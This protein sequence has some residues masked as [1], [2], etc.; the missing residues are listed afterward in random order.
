MAKGLRVMVK[1]GDAVKNVSLDALPSVEGY[2][3]LITVQASGLP[4]G[5]ISISSL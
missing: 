1:K 4:K 3:A 5:G 2:G